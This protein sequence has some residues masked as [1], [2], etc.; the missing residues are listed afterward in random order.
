MDQFSAHNI[1]NKLPRK[2]TAC[3]YGNINNHRKKITACD[4]ME[5]TAIKCG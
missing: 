3:G 4:Q 1:A 5:Q 2:K